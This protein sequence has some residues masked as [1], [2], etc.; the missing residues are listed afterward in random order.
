MNKKI[1][2]IITISIIIIIIS[3]FKEKIPSQIVNS[4]NTQL[5]TIKNT[6][7]SNNISKDTSSI[8]D[9]QYIFSPEEIN[10]HDLDG[11]EK[12]YEFIYKNEVFSAIYTYDNWKII[13]S[14]K[15]TSSEDIKIIC[16]A[17]IDIH[18]IHGSDMILYRTA[19]DMTYEWLQHNLAY[20]VL[21]DD[22]P[23]KEHAKNVDLNPS[24]QYK[25]ILDMYKSRTAK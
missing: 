23:W 22:N 17:L 20:S 4:S 6:I 19:E 11:K 7:I 24:D 2:V 12:N 15:I 25:N 16:Q 14:Y 10:L 8:K 1:F 18:P 5:N 9:N 3:I 21:P 13:N